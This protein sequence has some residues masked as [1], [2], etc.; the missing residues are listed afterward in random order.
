[1]YNERGELIPLE[2]HDLYLEDWL[3][4]RELGGRVKY[5]VSPGRHVSIQMI[6]RK[7]RA[8]KI[9][10]AEAS[11]STDGNNWWVSG[12]RNHHT[13]SGYRCYW[14]HLGNAGAK[15]F[16]SGTWTIIKTSC[17]ACSC[18]SYVDLFWAISAY[19]HILLLTLQSVSR[20]FLF[21]FSFVTWYPHCLFFSCFSLL[22][23]QQQYLS[24]KINRQR[25]LW[26]MQ[27]MKRR[28]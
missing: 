7:Q 17:L 22:H 2:Q 12:Q 16:A 25:H 1:M 28:C 6:S 13:L 3:G 26:K 24:S 18:H 11:W 19:T 14:L 4:L 27:C 20:C 21:L 10:D 15:T 23:F 9:I 8:N 5:L